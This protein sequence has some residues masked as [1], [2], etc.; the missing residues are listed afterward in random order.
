ME[1]FHPIVPELGI[2]TIEYDRIFS[3]FIPITIWL[4]LHFVMNQFINWSTKKDSS[5]NH[6]KEHFLSHSRQSVFIDQRISQWFLI[7]NFHAEDSHQFWNKHWQFPL[8]ITQT[9]QNGGR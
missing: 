4:K 9:L 2:L 7:S 6:P 3:N 5:W 1:T 8:K